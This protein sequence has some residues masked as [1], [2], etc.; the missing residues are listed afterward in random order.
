[1]TNT[2]T[3]LKTLKEE[4]FYTKTTTPIQM[5]NQIMKRNPKSKREKWIKEYALELITQVA[6]NIWPY[7]NLTEIERKSWCLNWAKNRK[8]YSRWWW[9]LIYDWDIAE[10]LATPT[11]LKRTKN[12]EKNPNKREQRLDTQARALTQARRLIE[13]TH[14]KIK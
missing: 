8:E 12:G 10:R 7:N 3:E 9:S 5:S 11:E 13:N 2:Q 4:I 6:E 1:M 14:R